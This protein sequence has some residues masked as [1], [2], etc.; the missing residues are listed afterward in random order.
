MSIASP[1]PQP[2]PAAASWAQRRLPPRRLG[3]AAVIQQPHSLC[4]LIPSLARHL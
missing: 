4:P 3:L 1:R 2:L